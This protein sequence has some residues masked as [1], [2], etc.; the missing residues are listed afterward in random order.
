MKKEEIV[1]Q[2]EEAKTLTSQVDIDKV[3]ALINQIEPETKSGLTFE[4]T[5]NILD[6]IE[7]ALDRN[8][9]HLVNKDTAE[10]EINYGNTVELDRVDVDINEIM[11]HVKDAI[12][13]FVIIEEDDDIVELEKGDVMQSVNEEP[14]TVQS[15]MRE[16]HELG[17]K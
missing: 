17:N 15:A 2:L 11:D 3:I 1:K 13:E 6:K 7:R 5:Q 9:D 8:S 16:F 12:D 14:F 4:D 10:F